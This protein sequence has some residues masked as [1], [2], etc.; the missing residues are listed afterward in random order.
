MSE[1]VGLEGYQPSKLDRSAVRQ[2]Q[3]ID[4]RKADGITEGSVTGS[5]Q[6]QRWFHDGRL[7]TQNLLSQY[8]VN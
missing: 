5:S 6:L 8:M 3:L 4:D 1:Q 2:R 7:A